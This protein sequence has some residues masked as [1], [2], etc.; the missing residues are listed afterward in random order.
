MYVFET[1]S[2][3]LKQVATVSQLANDGNRKRSMHWPEVWIYRAH[4][5]SMPRVANE[6][7]VCL[8]YEDAIVE[9]LYQWMRPSVAREDWMISMGKCFFGKNSLQPYY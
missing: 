3:S 8:M 9:S 5:M 6:T 2:Q 7:R 4:S 1:V